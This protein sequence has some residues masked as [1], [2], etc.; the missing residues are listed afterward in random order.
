APRGLA[1]AELDSAITE[2]ART[3][4]DA[5]DPRAGELVRAVWFPADAEGVLLLAIH[6]LAVDVVSWHIMIDGLAAAWQQVQAGVTPKMLPEFTSYRQWSETLWQRATEPEV[7]AQRD[8]WAAQVSAP[9][10]ALGARLPAPAT[11]TWSTLRVST[12]AT[13]VPL[14]ERLLAHVGKDEGV[15]ELLLTA[16]T[17]TM[18]SVHADNGNDPAAGALIAL[19]GHGRA[20][21][22][23]GTDT[24]NTLGWFTSVFPVR[25]GVGDDAVDVARAQADPAAARTLLDGVTTH[26]RE[27][28][29]QGLDYGLLRYVDRV[30]ELHAAAEPQV[31]FNYLGRI[32]LSGTEGNP[33][34]LLVGAHDT[35]L[36][37][38]P[39]PDLPLRYAV[40]VIAGI[41]TTPDG[42]ALTTN[43][44][45]PAGR[46][47]AVQR[48]HHQNRA[49]RAWRDHQQAI[50]LP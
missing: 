49:V 13:P 8:Y 3:A 23:L 16:L 14:T 22:E 47:H 25:L 34:S 39:E 28:P 27:I 19:E 44:R 10:A 29:N 26:L 7:L 30:P 41:G 12:V 43:F 15:R 36:P 20:D 37:L 21:A 33:W 40:D 4:N 9:D 6:H 31:E 50:D 35:A 46:D 2:F 24:A 11:D 42:P 32:D 1:G 48:A 45:L 18:A 5:I 17:M 38:D